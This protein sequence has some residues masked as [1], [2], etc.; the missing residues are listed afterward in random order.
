MAIVNLA[1]L[2]R[3]HISVFPAKC[4]ISNLTEIKMNHT[5]G[6]SLPLVIRTDLLP[7]FIKYLSTSTTEIDLICV[8][9][10]F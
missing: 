9:Y 7:D 5:M 4:M 2:E 3:I 10:Y 6:V 8:G 1:T